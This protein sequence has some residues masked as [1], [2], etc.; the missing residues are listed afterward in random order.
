MVTLRSA[1]KQPQ[2]PPKVNTDIVE[3]LSSDS[4][5]E[6]DGDD[7]EALDVEPPSSV[8]LA[9]PSPLFATPGVRYGAD[10]F[11]GKE[12]EEVEEE[13]EGEGSEGEEEG[14]QGEQVSPSSAKLAVRPKGS[15]SPKKGRVSIEIPVPKSA[16]KTQRSR[17]GASAGDLEKTSGTPKSGKRITFDDSDYDEFV[18]PKEAPA[19]DPLETHAVEEDEEE[20]EEDSD[21]EAPEAVSTRTAEAE[22]L[23]AAGAAAKAAEQ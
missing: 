17:D 12:E 11:R 20:E 21:D 13:A 8:T 22:T 7:D 3:I 19:E 18:T 4:E 23:K 9:D 2:P 1:G 15:R 16:S 10:K 14:P 6:V 5:N